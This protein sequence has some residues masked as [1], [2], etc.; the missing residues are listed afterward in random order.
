MQV[1]LTTNWGFLLLAGHLEVSDPL[2][3]SEQRGMRLKAPRP[4][5]LMG[6]AGG[7]LGGTVSSC[8]REDRSWLGKKSTFSFLKPHHVLVIDHPV[9]AE[10][11]K[12]KRR[13][14]MVSSGEKG[15]V[16]LCLC[17]QDGRC[18]SSPECLR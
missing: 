17:V 11:S 14:Q 16:P 5:A 9:K 18:N 6:M 10:E 7:G 12:S 3:A 8:G 13:D 1:F 2:S 4:P 15:L